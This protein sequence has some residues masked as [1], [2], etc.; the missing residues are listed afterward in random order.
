MTALHSGGKFSY[1]AYATAGGLHGVGVSVVNA[2]SADTVVEVARN[3]ALFRQSFSRGHPT[4]GLE[5]LGATPNRGGT[6]VSFTPD[7]EI[8]GPT[9]HFRP[10]RLYRLARSKAYLFRG[11]EIRWKCAPELLGD[12]TPARDRKSTRLNSSH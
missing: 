9:A 8:F 1:K 5:K 11:V 12:D 2:L 10:A 6:S 3:K 4:S 7:T